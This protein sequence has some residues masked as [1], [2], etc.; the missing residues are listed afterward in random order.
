[1]NRLLSETDTAKLLKSLTLP[2]LPAVLSELRAAQSREASGAE[3]AKIIGRDLGL[4]A[5]VLKTANSPSFAAG[6]LDSLNDA[7]HFLGTAN[8]DSVVT[9]VA[10]KRALPLPPIL[11]MFWEESTRIA[12]IAA[13]LAQR[14]RM[15]RPDQAYLF[16]LFR[17]CGIPVLTQRFPSY[18]NTL[19]RAM[20][21]PARFIEIEQKSRATSHVVVGYLLARTWFLPELLAQAILYHHDFEQLYDESLL[22]L[23]SARLIALARLAE[24]LMQTRQRHE[25]DPHWTD[26]QDYILTTLS[27]SSEAYDDA[28]ELVEAMS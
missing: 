16:C 17:D 19:A 24:H 23:D 7:L 1:M 27:I 9:G 3:L 15:V 10:L 22:S 2:A 11:G 25:A 28:A 18:V 12:A 20:A 13:M 6:K 26:I 5:A 14:W 21:S 8:L 4:S